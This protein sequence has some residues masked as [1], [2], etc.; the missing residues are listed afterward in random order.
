MCYILYYKEIHSKWWYMPLALLIG[1]LNNCVWFYAAK[2]QEGR[3]DM[4]VFSAFSSVFITCV[5]FL[6]P[7]VFFSVK[8]NKYEILGITLAITGL[9]LLKIFQ[10]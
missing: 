2:I 10:N 5:Y 7:I 6:L 9:I 8:L 4:Y 1:F 3:K